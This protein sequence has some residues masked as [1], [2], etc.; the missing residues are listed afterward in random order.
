MPWQN[1]NALM[2]GRLDGRANAIGA[3]AVSLFIIKIS[4]YN[5]HLSSSFVLLPLIS[6][7]MN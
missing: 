3:N 7:G 1:V 2:K 6:S 5:F 4:Y